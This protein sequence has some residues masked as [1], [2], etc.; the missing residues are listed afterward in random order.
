MVV[1]EFEKEVIL[2]DAP[3]EWSE[4]ITKWV[5]DN[6]KKPITYVAVS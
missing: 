3:P 4:T 1:I 2:C 5:T 6:L